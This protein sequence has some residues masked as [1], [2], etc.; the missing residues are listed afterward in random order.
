MFRNC[1]SL[2]SIVIP[3]KV[4]SIEDVAFYNCARLKSIIIPECVESIGI[5]AFSNCS[6]LKSV[7]IPKSCIYF[8]REAFAWC[9]KL[10]TVYYAGTKEAWDILSDAICNDM[11]DLNKA[12]ILYNYMVTE[13]G[14]IHN[15]L[16]KTFEGEDGSTSSA[17]LSTITLGNKSVKSITWQ[18]YKAK[19][20]FDTVLTGAGS[21]YVFGLIV[22]NTVYF[23]GEMK[24]TIEYFE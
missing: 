18:Y 17:V 13:D 5:M 14:T 12:T 22:P 15:E 19:A 3:D 7:A 8:E 23:L 2:E 1:V 11:S 6:S 20:K 21:S 24:T 9:P 16:L 4:T 10:E